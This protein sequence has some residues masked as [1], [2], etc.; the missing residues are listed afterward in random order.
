[1]D[2]Y[3][4]RSG[5]IALVLLRVAVGWHFLYEGASKLLNAD[6]SSKAYLI[7]SKGFLAPFF[8]W[9]AENESR[10][11][12]VDLLNEWGL[13]LIGLGLITGLL[14]R[15]SAIAGILLLAFYYLSHPAWPGLEY[16]FPSTGSFFIVDKNIV[17]IFALLV[18]CFFP[19]GNIIGL[20]RFFRKTANTSENG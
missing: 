10:L 1:M 7:D 12:V 6:W 17:E 4:S 18:L 16:M 15:T 8:H 11:T 2:M 19:T 3:Y 9:L 14:T 20:D 5:L 13:T